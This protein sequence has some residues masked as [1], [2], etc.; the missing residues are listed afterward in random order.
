MT[1]IVASGFLLAIACGVLL[2]QQVP[3]KQSEIAQVELLSPWELIDGKMR[4]NPIKHARSCF[5]LVRLQLRCGVK[6]AISYGNRFGDNWDI[7][8]LDSAADTQSRMVDLGAKDWTDKFDVPWIRPWAKLRE[9]EQRGIAVNTS[10]G[11]AGA[12]GY[13]SRPVAE[14]VSSTVKTE[15]DVERKDNYNPFLEVKKGHIY[16]VRVV[17][18]AND[19]YILFRV[20]DLERGAKATISFKKIDGPTSKPVF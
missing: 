20:D 13:G 14:Q 8:S 7:F 16:A 10:G 19:F 12:P 9:G 4:P 2:G 15:D 6:Q 11:S 5:D 17:D 3:S 1:K 18:P